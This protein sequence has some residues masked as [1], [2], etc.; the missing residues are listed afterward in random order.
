VELHGGPEEGTVIVGQTTTNSPAHRVLVVDDNHDSADS[1]G[2]LLRMTGHDVRTAYD[3]PTA[4]EAARSYR[5][6]VAVVDLGL[7]RMDGC[8]VAR[9]LREQPGWDA[10]L[11][12][13][14]TGYGREEDRRRTREAGFDHHLVK[15]VEF[16]AL[17]R[18][19]ARS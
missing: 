14:L 8:E 3:G 10:V 17:Q 12:I 19:L 9:R 11:F 15:P 7:P 1:L 5:P 4:L 6:G 13:A 16:A 18:L 2:L